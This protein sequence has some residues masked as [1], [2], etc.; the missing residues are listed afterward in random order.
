MNKLSMPGLRE[1]E[2]WGQSTWSLER[3]GYIDFV[4]YRTSEVTVLP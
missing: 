4:W 2:R 3:G 1:T